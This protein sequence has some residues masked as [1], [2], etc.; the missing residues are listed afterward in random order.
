MTH[1]DAGH[2]ARKHAQGTRV[3]PA[4]RDALLERTKD[5]K[6]PCA[7]AFDI[8]KRLGVSP[9]QVG[10]TADLMELRLVKCQL[11][12]FGYGRRKSIVKSVA[13]VNPELK[14]AILEALI[15]DRLPC[16]RAWEIAAAF[17]IHKLRVSAVCN[18]LG[19]RIKPCQ[20]GAF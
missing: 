1:E 8:A 9:G 3:N 6:L 4:I 10:Q 19:V 16:R 20:L 7:I 12:L 13:S 15:N 5:G 11:G 18:A 14:K 2:Y 17:G